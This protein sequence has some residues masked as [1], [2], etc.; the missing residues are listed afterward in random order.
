MKLRIALVALALG[1][2]AQ[3][4]PAQSEK[5]EV[6]PF[7]GFETSGSYPIQNSAT[8][9]SFRADQGLTF[10]TF[11]DYAWTDSFQFE[12]MWNRNQTSF[13]E[14]NT[15]SGLYTTAFNSDIDQ[16]HLGILYMFRGSE[17]KL[18]P[19]AAAG[20][21]FTH[22]SNSNSNP[23]DTEFS[24]GV[25]GGVKYYMNKRLG[26]RGDL[27]YVPTYANSSPTTY[28]DQFSNCFSAN[29][30]NYLNRVNFT[31]GIIIRF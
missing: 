1:L 28:C 14:H 5:W 8:V 24:Y 22:D 31:A 29:Q 7:V 13:S 4:L 25:G 16:F 27:R 3:V 15:A 19:Y 21:G 6:A 10:G 2:S 26:F 17:Q 18:R 12:G 20:L 9:D 30:R 23:S 11:V